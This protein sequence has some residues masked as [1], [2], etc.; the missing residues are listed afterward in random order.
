MLSFGSILVD[1]YRQR[2]RVEA[3]GASGYSSW[4]VDRFII[5][6]CIA[7]THFLSLNWRCQAVIVTLFYCSF[8]HDLQHVCCLHT[9][10]SLESLAA[11]SRHQK[12]TTITQMN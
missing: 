10:W 7:P 12:G 2:K 6:V 9:S 1:S 5:E 3:V 11:I 8:V 4:S